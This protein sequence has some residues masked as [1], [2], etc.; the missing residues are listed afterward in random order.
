MFHNPHG[1]NTWIS[2]DLGAI[3]N[4]S[5]IS[6]SLISCID[7]GFGCKTFFSKATDQVS[8]LCWL[9]E[10][11]EKNHLDFVHQEADCDGCWG[12][13]GGG[14]GGGGWHG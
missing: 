14:A 5:N 8:G 2:V 11:E 1:S 10:S 4:G 6:V 7:F 3:L 9:G 12:G 13:S